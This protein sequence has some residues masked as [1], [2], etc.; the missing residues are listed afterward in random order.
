[1]NWTVPVQAEDKQS[2]CETFL[3]D[4]HVKKGANVKSDQGS[5]L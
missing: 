4:S 5:M 2:M 1:L 3:V